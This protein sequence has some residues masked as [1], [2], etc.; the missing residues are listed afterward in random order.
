M[1]AD[2]I[3]KTPAVWPRPMSSKIFGSSKGI[4]STLMSTQVAPDLMVCL[5]TSG[6]RSMSEAFG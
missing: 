4:L 2:S 6:M 1:P 3:W 5:T